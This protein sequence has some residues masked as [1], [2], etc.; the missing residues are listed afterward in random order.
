MNTDTHTDFNAQAG[1]SDEVLATSIQRV[2]SL[3]KD[4]WQVSENAPVPK[5]KRKMHKT[6]VPGHGSLLWRPAGIRRYA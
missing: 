3:T 2:L 5:R 6:T 4:S 1:S